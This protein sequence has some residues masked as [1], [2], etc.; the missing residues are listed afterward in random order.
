MISPF[1]PFISEELWQR[2]PRRPGDETPTIIK[3]SYPVFDP[4]FDNE[5]AESSYTFLLDVVGTVRSMMSQFNIVKN[6][7][8]NLEAAY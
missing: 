7:S 6:S 8:G 2:L 1:M 5:A 3:A 4:S